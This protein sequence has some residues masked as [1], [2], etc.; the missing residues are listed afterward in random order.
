MQTHHGCAA[1]CAARLLLWLRRVPK[2]QPYIVVVGRKVNAE[3]CRITQNTCI[4]GFKTGS[5]LEGLCLLLYDFKKATLAVLGGHV[6]AQEN[7]GLP[8]MS[9]SPALQLCTVCVSGLPAGSSP[10]VHTIQ[11]ILLHSTSSC[12]FLFNFPLLD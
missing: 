2:N 5:L 9:P 12:L 10:W 1:T 7:G 3:S 6:Q 11:S 8:Q 4:L